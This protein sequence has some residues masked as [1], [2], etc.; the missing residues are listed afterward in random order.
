MASFQEQ[1]SKPSP[2]RHATMPIS[3]EGAAVGTILCEWRGSRAH[4]GAL[5]VNRRHQKTFSGGE[6]LSRR[7][8]LRWWLLHPRG[9][10]LL[11]T[12]EATL[13]RVENPVAAVFCTNQ[14]PRNALIQYWQELTTVP[15]QCLA[16]LSVVFQ[17]LL[18]LRYRFSSGLLTAA[19]DLLLVR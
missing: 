15:A 17:E 14:P 18:T 8:Q 1:S 13:A 19:K 10:Y 6:R 4:P 2:C 3:N 11:P 5:L 7:G 9:K 12:L 16:G